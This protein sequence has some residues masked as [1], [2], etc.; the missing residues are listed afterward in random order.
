FKERYYGVRP[1]TTAG[2]KSIVYRGPRKDEGGNVVMGPQAGTKDTSS[3][4]PRSSPIRG[5]T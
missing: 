5:Q 2:W 3:S 4:N 1:I